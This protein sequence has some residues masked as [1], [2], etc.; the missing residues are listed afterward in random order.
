MY[1]EINK[2]HIGKIKE[3]FED[4]IKGN[5][6]WFDEGELVYVISELYDPE[7]SD[8]IV[9]F[10]IML[11]VIK[12]VLTVDSDFVKVLSHGNVSRFPF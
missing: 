5:D 4:N 6:V 2:F 12:D 9:C 10:V 11:P 1:E 8:I 3:G 7:D